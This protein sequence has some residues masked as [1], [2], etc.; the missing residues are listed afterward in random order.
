MRKDG[1]LSRLFLL[2]EHQ[3]LN[4]LLVFLLT[5][6][7]EHGAENMVPKG[8][9]HAEAIVFIFIVM[10]M[11]IAPK[12]LH[13]LE[14][15]VPGVNGIVHAAIHQV[16]EY[17][18]R[19]EHECIL[20]DEQVDDAEY[21]RCDDQAGYRRHE[22]PLFIARIVVVIS[23]QRI[24]EFLRTRIIAHPVKEEA[25]REVF[26]K[27]P[28]EHTTEKSQQY[29]AHG[30]VQR[31][32]AVIKHIHNH[33]Q[34]HA[35]N[36]QGMCLGQHLQVIILKQP[37]LAFIVNFFELHSAKIR[38]AIFRCKGLKVLKL[39]VDHFLRSRMVSPLKYFHHRSA[40]RSVNQKNG[41][42]SD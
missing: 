1:R 39:A 19:E 31:G 37:G 28:E 21:G 12:T 14:G 38:K 5:L 30:I 13:P 41:K 20:T 42:K 15:R 26:E 8:G 34:V 10:E 2:C 7:I 36:N 4:F 40:G 35:P 29:S 16:S 3:L 11:M 33:G 6:Q 17:E 27:S 25:V 24:D 32:I 22:E 9:A 18:A 23:V